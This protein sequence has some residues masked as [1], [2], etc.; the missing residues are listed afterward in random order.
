MAAE[1]LFRLVC[2]PAA[3]AG[4]PQEWLRELLADAELALLPAAGPSEDPGRVAHALGVL[5][6]SVLRGE[7][8]S[9]DQDA[10]VIAWAGTMPLVW[11]APSF[12]DEVSAWARER[13]PMTLLVE[14]SGPLPDDEQR[15]VARFA[16]TLGRQS[17]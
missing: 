3:I 16:A 8:R 11:V 1:P 10:T 9:A 4:A 6:V 13:G 2:P 7:A 5:T 15:R 14:S 12:S 17:E